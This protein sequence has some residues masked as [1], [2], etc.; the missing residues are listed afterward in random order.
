[1]DIL[2]ER[3]KQY[4]AP[5][6]NFDCAARYISIYLGHPVSPHDVA[7]IMC[8]VKLARITT[9]VHHDDNY[10][11]LAGYAELARLLSTSFGAQLREAF[12]GEVL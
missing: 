1:M 7:V 12:A 8:C 11:D 4:G 2:D 6:I 10:V 3:A 9:G 5:E